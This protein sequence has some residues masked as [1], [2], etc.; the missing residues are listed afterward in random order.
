MIKVH[1][2][3]FQLRPEFAVGN[4]QYMPTVSHNNS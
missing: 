2:K 4:K 3:I 1:E